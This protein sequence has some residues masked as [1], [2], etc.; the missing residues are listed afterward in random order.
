VK[1]ARQQGMVL[2]PEIAQ[3][4]AVRV[5]QG[6][7]GVRSRLKQVGSYALR[8]DCPL[9]ARWRSSRE[10]RMLPWSISRIENMSGGEWL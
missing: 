2:Q 5:E 1:L 4:G 9:E 3:V 6:G 7:S 8:L 10:Y